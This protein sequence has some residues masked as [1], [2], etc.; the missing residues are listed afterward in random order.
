M[1]TAMIDTM[2][3][4]RLV[5]DPEAFAAVKLA[6]RERRLALFTT[7]VQEA[8]V[9]A[10]A[11]PRRRKQLR[12]VPREVLPTRDDAVADGR[13]HIAD[14]M[15]AETARARC[16]LLVTEDRRLTERSRAQGLEV[17]NVERLLGWVN[18]QASKRPV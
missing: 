14:A 5:D 10:V 18:G 3:F 16:D 15:I 11:D 12:T 2:V 17:W 13:R 1:V 6:L 9:A 7:P 8:Q 4:D